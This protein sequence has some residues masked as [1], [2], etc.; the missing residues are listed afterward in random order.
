[1]HTHRTA[2]LVVFTLVALATAGCSSAAT[3]TPATP[4]PATPAATAAAT[5]PAASAAPSTSAVVQAAIDAVKSATGPTDQWYGPTSAP[6]AAKN[7]SVVCINY[8]AQDVVGVAW[9]KGVQEAA[10]KIGW[11]EKTIDTQGTPD[12]WRTGVQQA[13]A[14]KPDGI[15]ISLDA[16]SVKGLL[17]EASDA[18]IPV[19]GIHSAGTPGPNPELY[20]YTNLSYDPVAQAKLAAQAAIADSNGTAQMIEITDLEYAI[21]TTKANTAKAEI[22]A[23][24][25]CKQLELVSTPAGQANSTMPGL[26]TSWLT[27]YPDMFYVYSVSDAGFLDPGIPP[28]RQGTVP[29]SG[30]IGLVGSDGSPSAYQRIK[31]GE[32]QIGTIPEPA[33]LQGWQAVDELNRAFNGAPPSGTVWP[34]HIITKDNIATS[35]VN[36]VYVPQ[37]DYASQYAKIWGVGQ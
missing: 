16:G 29:F 5:T 8:Y 2:S 32:Y 6:A 19:I 25:T 28:L 35:I 30:R 20:L 31:A 3:P 24:P 26:F 11:T 37:V 13:I 33:A 34:L 9:C 21:A 18:K 17:K 22:E 23:C 1:M 14:L 10:A 27:K 4:V 36:G 15:V 12:T 7:K